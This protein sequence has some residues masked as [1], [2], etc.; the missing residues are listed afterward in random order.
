MK[1]DAE[2][3][4]ANLTSVNTEKISLADVYKNTNKTVKL[5]LPPGV[6]VTNHDVLAHIVVKNKKTR[7]QVNDS[8][9]PKT[10]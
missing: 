5:E 2:N 6:T 1:G 3:V 9:L 4:I 8:V 10:R 7:S